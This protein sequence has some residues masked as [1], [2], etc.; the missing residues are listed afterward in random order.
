MDVFDV[1]G[2][3]ILKDASAT[4]VYGVRG[5]NGVIVVTTNRGRG[6]V[7][8]VITSYSIHYTKLYEPLLLLTVLIKG[9]NNSQLKNFLTIEN[10]L[11]HNEVTSI[12]QD[13]EGFMWIGTRGGLSY[14]FV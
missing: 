9:Q 8:P 10:G 1:K 4:A 3:N 6:E 11:S 7:M 13:H 5:A 2:I 12:V 14:N